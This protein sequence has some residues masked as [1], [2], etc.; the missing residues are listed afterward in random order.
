MERA[1]DIHGRGSQSVSRHDLNKTETQPRCPTADLQ[2]VR[3][4]QASDFTEF[5]VCFRPVKIESEAQ[6]TRVLIC[7]LILKMITR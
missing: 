2:L 6:A 3:Q 5:Q 4:P 1:T 7:E